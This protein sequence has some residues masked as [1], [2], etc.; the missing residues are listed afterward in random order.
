V[1]TAIESTGDWC[2][3]ALALLLADGA[4]AVRLVSGI[5]HTPGQ[6]PSQHALAGAVRALYEVREADADECLR[7]CDC[8]AA[9]LDDSSD[10]RR[11]TD[12]L[13]HTRAQWFRREGRLDESEALLRSL[14]ARTE[15]RVIV[16][17]YLTTAAL[18][19][20]ISMNGDDDTALEVY[21]QALVKAR[22]SGQDSLIVN[23]LNNLGA[24]Q[25]DLRNPEDAEPLLEECL[26]GACRLGS[27]RQ[28][29]YAAGNLVQCLCL[30]GRA[31]EALVI[32]RRHL[33]GLIRPD[34]PAALQRDEEIAMALLDNDLVDEAEVVLA[35]TP[36][37]DPMSNETM[38]VRD[39]LSARI[40]LARGRPVAALRLCMQRQDLLIQQGEQG[41]AA[42]DRV[43]LL[44]VAAQAAEQTGDPALAYRLLE[45]AFAKHEQL[46]GRAARSRQLSLQISHRLQHVEWERDAAKLT[47]TQ[48]E[49]LNASLQAQLAENER[50]QLLLQ[51]RAI[52]DP[53]TGLHNRRH[54]LEAGAA[55]LSLMR[56]RAEPLAVVMVDL[57]HFKRV[58]DRHGH[59][60]GDA[61][62][63]GFAEVVRGRLRAEDIVCRHG[64]EEF[65]LLLPGA[66]ATHAAARVSQL[67]ESFG[68]RKFEDAEGAFFTCT[69]SAGVT[70]S[71]QDGAALPELLARA[72]AALY[73]AKG[74]GRACVR[75]APPA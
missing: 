7:L 18:G 36:K 59:E 28:I 22:L 37:I 34:D 50:L 42:I 41:T 27:R 46:L 15:Q 25:C 47:A 65:V 53:L 38:T 49:A 19:T 16:D 56:R 40:L 6:R 30:M 63:R 20:V 43:H 3:R 10:G 32:A 35:R 26:A 69:F 13:A 55:L 39:S 31:E 29:I 9:L 54:L 62:L 14:H 57:D 73:A 5:L 44:R 45:Q 33:I 8:A 24:L 72:D 4:A 71:L 52:E 67:L 12:L 2:S 68:E 70:D 51:A 75:I 58:N 17:A 23:A 60:A 64:G 21:Y 61:A 74:A 1:S 11:C 48:L 66:P